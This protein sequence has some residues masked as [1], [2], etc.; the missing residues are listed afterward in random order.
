MVIFF[1]IDDTLIDSESAHIYAIQ[2]IYQYHFSNLAT[3]L[4]DIVHRWIEITNK[5]LN[6]FF[7]G[8]LTLEQ[9][10]INRIVE[11]WQINGVNISK[12]EAKKIY[13]QYHLFFLQACKIF[14]D[15][16]PTLEELKN[17]HQLGIISNGIYSDQMCKLKH[18][19]LLYLFDEIF[20]SENVGHSKP[21]KEI[22]L[23]AAR[24]MG[25]CLSQ[26]IYIGDSYKLDYLG[27]KNAGM[28]TILLDRKKTSNNFECNKIH[29]LFEL[30]NFNLN[31]ESI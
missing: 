31:K 16:M 29:S 27:G 9:Q 22:F 5:N 3:S 30:R 25:V 11:F 1:D 15:V 28:N 7:K 6:L 4:N 18:N 21:D 14:S 26:S 20:I 10:R 17:Y 13:S 8:E 19:N 23:Y 12:D 24:E 2:Q